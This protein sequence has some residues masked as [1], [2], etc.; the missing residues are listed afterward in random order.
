MNVGLVT[1]QLVCWGCCW[2]LCRRSGSRFHWRKSSA[3]LA[4]KDLVRKAV[5]KLDK[6]ASYCKPFSTGGSLGISSTRKS[7][8]DQFAIIHNY[9]SEA[10]ITTRLILTLI[11]QSR[12]SELVFIEVLLS[13]HFFSA[14]YLVSS[15]NKRFLKNKRWSKNRW[16][17]LGWRCNGCFDGWRNGH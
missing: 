17:S 13:G 7:G 14:T 16:S 15:K 9:A 6:V 2:C 5:I 1:Y 3:T 11:I 4:K 8:G 12:T 10:N